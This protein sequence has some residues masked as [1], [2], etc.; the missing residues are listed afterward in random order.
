[1]VAFGDYGIVVQ[2][3]GTCVSMCVRAQ[4]HGLADRITG[5]T[6]DDN[7]VNKNSPEE[8]YKEPLTR[9]RGKS[10]SIKHDRTG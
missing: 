6:D 5:S 1:M 4:E 7:S 8:S 2:G 9:K 3:T 10:R